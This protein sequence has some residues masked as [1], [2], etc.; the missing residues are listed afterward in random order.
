MGRDLIGLAAAAMLAMGGS[1][2]AADAPQPPQ[3]LAP[4]APPGTPA[5]G[6]PTIALSKI[7]IRILDGAPYGTLELGRNCRPHSRLLWRGPTDVEAAD[8]VD[9]A[10]FDQQLKAFGF[11][12]AGDSSDLFTDPGAASAEFQVGAEV[13]EA[14]AELC[15]ENAGYDVLKERFLGEFQNASGKLQLAMRWQIYSSLDRRVV[16]RIETLAGAQVGLSS[17][18]VQALIFEASRQNIIA[19]LRTP[20]FREA[21]RRSQ[22]AAP[23]TKAE[24]LALKA[25]TADLSIADAVGSVTAIFAGDGMGSGFVIADGYL[26]TDRHVVGESEKVRVKWSDGLETAGEVVRSDRRR[27]VAL[28]RTDTRGRPALKP[29]ME[30]VSPGETVFAIGSPLDPKFQGTVTR[31]AVSAFRTFD[32]FAYI[33]SDVTVNPGNSGGPLLDQ[34]GRVVGLTEA[35]YRVESAPTGINL[36]TP[37]RDAIDFLSVKLQAS[38]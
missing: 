7:A 36:F 37:I 30:P 12:T 29:R 22:P 25:S 23:S 38:R 21:V 16:A 19:L 32:G 2:G 24:P 28:I 35:G 20:E 4:A 15:Y 13:T 27:D 17:N 34:K 1:A 10:A 9:R 18:T 5:E 14:R 3:A 31:G 6:S 33:Q 11:R 8:D 26:L